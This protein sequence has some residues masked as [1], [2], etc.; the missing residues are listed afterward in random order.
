MIREGSR[1]TLPL[2]ESASQGRRGFIRGPPRAYSPTLPQG[3]RTAFKLLEW[4]ELQHPPGFAGGSS[5]SEGR[6]FGGFI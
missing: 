1:F 5:D 6:V 2:G 3:D 4:Q